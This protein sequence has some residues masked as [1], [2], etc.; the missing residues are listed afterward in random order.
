MSLL[1]RLLLA[2]LLLGAATARAQGPVDLRERETEVGRLQDDDTRLT[3]QRVQLERAAAERAAEIER[4]RA[5]SKNDARV[6]TL[7][8][9]QRAR[10]DELER[11]QAELR[12][13]SRS[14]ESARRRLIEG[15]DRALAA[16]Q[17]TEGRRLELT[18]L[19]AIQVAALTSTTDEAALGARRAA[20]VGATASPLDGPRELREKVDLLRDSGD[21]LRREATRLQQAIASVER[22]RRLRERAGS[23]DEDFFGEQQ[24]NRRAGNQSSATASA[25]GEWRDA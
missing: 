23:V 1:C 21:K 24:W 16:P 19:R 11:V 9:E 12:W 10:T 18:R 22:R 3:K 7:L 13:R 2:A 15:Y 6:R 25:A 17:L 14:L 5:D 8:A 20:Q 4:L